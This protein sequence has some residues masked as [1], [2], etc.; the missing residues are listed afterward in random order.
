[1]RKRLIA[2]FVTFFV[3]FNSFFIF[4]FAYT[5][6]FSDFPLS[7]VSVSCWPGS[8]LSSSASQ[9]WLDY[10]RSPS[11]YDAFF[12]LNSS[13]NY[14]YKTVGWPGDGFNTYSSGNIII[15]PKGTSTVSAD[16]RFLYSTSSVLLLQLSY[17]TNCYGVNNYKFVCNFTYYSSFPSFGNS[18]YT[19]FLPVNWS[20]TGGVDVVP[21]V[22]ETTTTTTTT[23]ATTT[24][25]KPLPHYS[26]NTWFV[27]WDTDVLLDYDSRIKGAIQVAVNVGFAILA[28]ILGVLVMRRII[29]IFE[30]NSA[31]GSGE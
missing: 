10:L 18:T 31:G 7:G 27:P 12:Y 28:V 17:W 2:F 29:L 5:F 16:G 15:S 13:T 23:I 30:N 11:S 9:V 8:S 4:A 21:R 25:T 19:Y 26:V 22:R 3:F 24:T 6:D 1:M 14:V 20:I